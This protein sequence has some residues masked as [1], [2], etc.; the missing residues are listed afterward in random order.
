MSDRALRRA[1]RATALDEQ[2]AEGQAAMLRQRL[3]AGMLLP[4]ECPVCLG[5]GFTG[6]QAADPDLL[7]QAVR[8]EVSAD[9]AIRAKLLSMHCHRCDGTGQQPAARTIELA[10]MLRYPGA[11]LL[12]SSPE[13]TPGTRPFW[14]TWNM[15]DRYTSTSHRSWGDW[16]E[17]L[18]ERWGRRLTVRLATS[19]F[20]CVW[21]H[22]EELPGASAIGH[23]AAWVERALALTRA[24]CD[25]P[26]SEHA[27]AAEQHYEAFEPTAQDYRHGHHALRLP[28]VALLLLG[29][30]HLP[31]RRASRDLR[32]PMGGQR[33]CL[34]VL[35]ECALRVQLDVVYHEACRETAAWVLREPA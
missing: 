20:S 12:T 6:K 21:C 13:S 29:W 34:A 5:Y 31:W 30:S 17:W 23:H 7:H 28:W 3:R 33:D 1:Q 19:A 8:G 32:A 16:C 18:A 11:R 4:V 22:R 25:A 9:T 35:R 26:S 15:V 27:G 24:W 10:A 2:D 14:P